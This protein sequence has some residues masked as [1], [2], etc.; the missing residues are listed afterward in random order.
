MQI[1]E[2]RDRIAKKMRKE[3]REQ[4]K[5]NMRDAALNRA[6]SMEKPLLSTC[7]EDYWDCTQW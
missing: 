6:L 1:S 5:Q 7:F 4:I 2:S 3:N